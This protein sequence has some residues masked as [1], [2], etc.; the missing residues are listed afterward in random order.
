[1]I[2]FDMINLN[3][4]NDVKNILSQ[5]TIVG[6]IDIDRFKNFLDN[7][8]YN[9]MIY[10]ILYENN[11]AGIG[12]ILIE[13]KIIHNF[14]KVGHIEDIVIDSKFRGLGLG[15]E[16]INFLVKKGKKL[17][18]YKIILDCSDKMVGFYSKCGFK[19][20][21]NMMTVRF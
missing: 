13:N 4:F 19:R 17:G 16:L 8:Q 5:L 21:G 2:T 11:V 10:V 7:L 9:H 20:E 18:C 1:M 6:N 15:K 12:T 14:G 3:H